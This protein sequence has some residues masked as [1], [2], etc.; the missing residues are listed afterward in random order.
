M[1]TFK[2]IVAEFPQIRIDY[3]RQQPEHKAPLACFLSHVHSDHLAGLESLRAPFVYCSAATREILLRLE[4]YHYRINFARCLLE[5]R[6]VTYKNNISRLAKPLP[7][8]TP[9]LIELSPGNCIRVT[10][11]DA[12]HCVGAVM[13]LIE[14]DGKAFLYTGDVR[15]ETWWVNS[16]VQNPV[17]LPYACGVKRLDCVY[18]DTTFATKSAPYRE[19]PS[20]AEGIRELLEKVAKY[21]KDTIFYFHSWT[22]GYENVWIALSSF[23]DSQI[24]LDSYRSRIYGSLSPLNNKHLRDL[25]IEIREASALCG[26]KNGNHHQP[27]C[28]TSSPDVRI[29]SCERGMGC[30]VMDQDTDAKIVSIVPIITRANGAEI[31]EI[32]AGGGKGD[33]DQKEELE[34]ADVTIIGKL[35]EL[36]ANTLKDEDLLSKVLARLQE[37]LEDGKGTVDLGQSL[38][39]ESQANEDDLTLQSLVSVLSNQVAERDDSSRHETIRFPYSRHSSYS[40]LCTLVAALR[41]MDVYPCTVDERTWSP[42]M[43][44][45]SLF[46]EYCS[47]DV[48]RHDAEMMGIYEERVERERKGKRE[49]ETQTQTTDRDEEPITPVAHKKTKV[50]D[51]PSS[52]VSTQFVTPQGTPLRACGEHERSAAET[53]DNDDPPQLDPL[54]NESSSVSGAEEEGPILNPRENEVS[55][56]SITPPTALATTI[57]PGDTVAEPTVTPEPPPS[58]PPVRLSVAITRPAFVLSSSAQ[59]SFL[60]SSTIPRRS[61]VERHN[62]KFAYNAASGFGLTWAEYGGLISARRDDDEIE[63]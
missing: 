38:Q 47:A 22:F 21:P 45:R 6:T 52:P 60:G 35:M 48:F 28:L 7:L 57:A 19:F 44:M 20:K 30:P 56:H 14:G 13:F 49:N 29:H 25:G 51:A 5:S 46:G 26:F 8:D 43:S 27:G 42:E 2:G 33:L 17:L 3:F 31:A 36:C 11:L 58:S 53:R 37:A 4:K 9:T 61:K 55:V 41:P 39:K 1:S 40:E 32:G 62:V 34:A 63:L 23:L 50:L 10:L 24:H 54:L 18:M 16:I 12:N 59:S 15:A